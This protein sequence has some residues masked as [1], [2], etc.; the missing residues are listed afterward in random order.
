MT[1]TA[2]RPRTRRKLSD[3]TIK[4][5]ERR[6][7]FRRRFVPRSSRA[8]ESP[9]RWPHEV[10]GEQL[11]DELVAVF[12]GYMV[13]P[14]GGAETL[15]LWVVHAHAHDAAR[16][17][18]ILTIK[19]PEKRC[20]K[21]RLLSL[22]FELVPRPQATSNITAANVFRLVD[23]WSPTLLIDEGDTFIRARGGELRGILD[24]GHSRR[25]ATV[26][27]M[28]RGVPTAFS[29]WAPKAIAL[30]GNL[31]ATLEDRSIIIRLKRKRRDEH[32]EALPDPGILSMRLGRLQSMAGRW[33]EDRFRET[34]SASPDVPKALNDRATDNWRTLLAIADVVGDGWRRR[35][36]SIAKKAARADE[37][38]ESPAITLLE[39]IAAVFDGMRDERISSREL[40]NRLVA[41]EERPWSEF[42][43]GRALTVNMLAQLLRPFGIRSRQ[44][45]IHGRNAHGYERSAFSDAFARYVR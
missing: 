33:A 1:T 40:V 35:A 4:R 28:S 16:V 7:K 10:D 17:S 27:R 39:D 18:P 15:A 13:L 34:R 31:P 30:I 11:L 29:T 12:E 9:D 43:N 26:V 37:D 42:R 38:E 5:L 32:V 19:S 44:L 23:A 24:S 36:F 20:G 21:T 8:L 3:R 41:M 2:A 25:A 22:L 14:D 6:R 45:W